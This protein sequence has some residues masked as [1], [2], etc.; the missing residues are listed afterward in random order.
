M[1]IRVAPNRGPWTLALLAAVGLAA[2]CSAAPSAL[3]DSTAEVKINGEA[4]G[5]PYPVTCSQNGWAWTV[6][7]QQQDTGFTAVFDTEPEMTAQS[8]EITGL[9]GF[10]GSFWAGTVGKGRAGVANGKFRIS[11][12]AVGSFADNPTDTVDAEFS[13]EAR[14]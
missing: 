14:C 6:Q 11:G 10:T 8:V 5:G 2:G 12:T 3:G 13:I 4:A 7:T 9:N 1:G